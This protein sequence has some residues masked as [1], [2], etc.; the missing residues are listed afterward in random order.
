MGRFGCLRVALPDATVVAVGP[1]DR[2]EVPYTHPHPVVITIL[3]PFTRAVREV[4][5]SG[6]ADF[7]ITRRRERAKKVESEHC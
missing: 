6:S 2:F 4:Q 7:K 5:N 3:V 1:T